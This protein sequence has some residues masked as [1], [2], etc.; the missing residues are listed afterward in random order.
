[1]NSTSTSKNI[2]TGLDH[3]ERFKVLLA[4]LTLLQGRFDKYDQLIFTTRG[5]LITIVVAVLGAALTLKR[6]ELAM[7]A[8]GMPV[9]FYAV[10]ILWRS[11]YWYKYVVRYRAVRTALNTGQAVEGISVYDLTNHYGDRPSFWQSIRACAFRVEPIFFYAGLVIA[12]FIVYWRIGSRLTRRCSEPRA[13]LRLMF[14][15]FAIHAL[16]AWRVA[17]G[18]R[19]LILCLV[20]RTLWQPSA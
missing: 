12:G 19:S 5:W 13:S 8:A 1:V 20:R 9:F 11:G 2:S 7:L 4:E 17:A 14:G 10:E 6:T 15:V 18:S 16:A 3:A